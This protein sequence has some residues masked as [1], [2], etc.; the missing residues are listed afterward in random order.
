MIKKHVYTHQIDLKKLEIQSRPGDEFRVL[1]EKVTYR[2][3][4]VEL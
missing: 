2:G 4:E 3:Y 1:L